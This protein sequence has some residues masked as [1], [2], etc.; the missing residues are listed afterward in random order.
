MQGRDSGNISY[1]SNIFLPNILPYRDK[2]FGFSIGDIVRSKTGL[3]SFL[4]SYEWKPNLF[5][6]ANAVYRR[7]AA[8]ILQ[9]SKNTFVIYAGIRWNMHR[10]EFDF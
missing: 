1:G 2:D 7:E 3:A 6:E 8:T 4:V 9:P 10:R 5:L